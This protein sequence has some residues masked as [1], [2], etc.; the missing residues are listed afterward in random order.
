MKNKRGQV[1]G[2]VLVVGIIMIVMFIGFIMVTG[3]AVINYVADEVVP[4]LSDLGMVENANLTEYAEYTITPANTFIQNLNWITGVLYVM[5]LIGCF[6]LAF[7]IRINPSKVLIGFFF[8]LVVVL[9]LASIFVSNIY[10][11]FYDDGAGS[12]LATRLQENVILSYMIL[13]AP[14]INTIIAFVTG[15]IIFSGR[16][17]EEVYV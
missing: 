10:Q 6:G 7:I 12:E 2:L 11:D 16:A 5:M 15:I 13:Y 3:N 4:E 1:L 14:M 17:E 9:I 8:L